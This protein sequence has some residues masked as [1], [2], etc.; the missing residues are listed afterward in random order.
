MG[1]LLFLFVFKFVVVNYFVNFGNNCI[2]KMT[3]VARKGRV[4]WVG[5]GSPCERRGIKSSLRLLLSHGACLAR[6][7]ITTCQ[8]VD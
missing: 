6:F 7:T 4:E 1:S 3:F 5:G 8:V 2:I